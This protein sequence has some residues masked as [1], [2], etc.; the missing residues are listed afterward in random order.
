MEI[1]TTTIGVN[2]GVSNT[3]SVQS[4]S[5]NQKHPFGS[6]LEKPAF[7]RGSDEFVLS[8]EALEIQSAAMSPS[9]NIAAA[10]AERLEQIKAEIASGTYDDDVKL[11][12]AMDRLLDSILD[13]EA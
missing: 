2:Q 13:Q 1:R 6:S 10:R 9:S 12:A 11:E 3:N 4:K 7:T 5:L 8:S